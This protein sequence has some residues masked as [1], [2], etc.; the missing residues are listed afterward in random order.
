MIPTTY[1]QK[2]YVFAPVE[3]TVIVYLPADYNLVTDDDLD[4]KENYDHSDE[5]ECE[6]NH[7]CKC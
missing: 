1:T 5:E 4:D 3:P 2:K 6:H 7:W